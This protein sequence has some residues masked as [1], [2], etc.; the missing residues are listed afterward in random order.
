M[1]MN[2]DK[3]AQ[4]VALAHES[5]L[6]EVLRYRALATPDKLAYIFLEDGES[7][8]LPI[9]YSELDRQARRVAARLQTGS[10]DEACGRVLLIYPQGLEFVVAFFGC[11]YAGTTAVLSYPPT[12][13]KMALRVNAIATDCEVGTVLTT[14]ELF[15]KTAS[16]AGKPLADAGSAAVS[17][18]NRLASVPWICTDTLEQGSEAAFVER[19][20]AADHV[21]FLQYTSGSTG[22]PKGVMVT[23]ANLMAN[24][25]SIQAIY[26]SSDSSVGVG[27]LP[28][29][30]DMGLIGNVLHP[31]FAGFPLIFMSPLHFMQRPA[32]WLRAIAKYRAT[33]SGGPNFSYDLCSEKIALDDVAG[34]DLSCWRVAFNGAEPV[35]ESTIRRFHDKF[36][37]LGLDPQAH[38]AVYGLAEATLIVSG[39]RDNLPPV[40]DSETGT[41]SSGTA[42]PCDVVAAVDP[43]RQVEVPEG[44]EGEIWVSG[45]SVAAGYWNRAEETRETFHATLPG[46]PRR[47]LRTGDT[48]FIRNG[49]VHITGRIKDIVIVRGRNYHA[50][51]LEWSLAGIEHLR[52]GCTAVFSMEEAGRE[53]L[54]LVAGATTTDA[55]AL[56]VVV[57]AARAAVYADH[58]L[59]LDRIVLIRPKELPTTTSGKVQRRL[60]RRTLQDGGFT[61]LLDRRLDGATPVEGA[62]PARSTPYVAPGTDAERMLA[63]TWAAVLQ[64]PVEGIGLN[65]NFFELGGSSLTMLELSSR[66]DAPMELLFR[67][68]T[69]AGWLYRSAEYERPDV[70]ADIHLPPPAIDESLQGRT[71]ISMITGGTGFFGLHYLQAMMKRS[72]DRFVLPVRGV[73]QQAIERKFDEAVAYFGLQADID[74]SRVH[75]VCGDLGKPRVGLSEREYAWVARNV[76]RI[77]HIGSHVNNWLPYEGIKAIN[78]EGTRQL[79]AL[80]RTGRRKEFHY[81]STST[82]SP[83]KADKTVFDESDR[84]D[85]ADINRYFGYDLSKYV[86]EELCVLARAEGVAC[87]I[88]RL[89]WVGGHLASG[90]TKVNDGLNIMLRILLTLGCYP[91][92]EYL[93][94]VIPVDL[95]AESMASLVDRCDNTSFNVTSQSKEA[96]DMKRIVAI[97][98]GMGYR[99][100]ELSRAEFVERLRAVPAE[101]WDEQ[102]R[103]YRQLIIRLFE[104]PTPKIESYYD[105]GNF[106]SRMDPQVLA[107]MERKFIDS[108]FEKTVNFLVRRGAL[109]TP[110]GR[111]F[112]E[113]LAQ[114]EKWNETAAEFPAQA[115]LHELFER[116]VHATPD[117]PAVRFHAVTTSYRELNR[118]AEHV[119]RRLRAAGVAPR[120]KVGMSV[121]RSTA[122]IAAI[123]G[124]F[125]AGCAYVPLD[126]TYPVQ[127]LDFMIEDS[128]AASIVVDA[129]SAAQLAQHA[130]ALLVLDEAEMRAAAA[131]GA[132]DTAAAAVDAK[133]AAD[134]LAYVIY[135]SGTTGK[136][137]GVMVEHRSVVNHNHALMRAFEL[138][139]A[140]TMLQFSTVNFDSFVE[141]VFPTLFSGATLVMVDKEELVDLQRFQGA[142]R[143]QGVTIVK[144]STAFWHTIAGLPLER[145]GVRMVGIGG[146]AADL[147]KYRTWRTANPSLPLL[148]T[149]GPTEITVTA[150]IARLEGDVQ[151]ITIGRPIANTTVRVL[152]EALN[153]VP[154]GCTGELY[155]GGAGVARGYLQ[156]PELTERAF[157]DDPFGARGGSGRL[158]RSG[159]LVRWTHDGEL[160]FLGRADSQV[161]VRG[162]RIE[163][164]AIEGLLAAQ[165]GVTA[166]A[167][168]VKESDAKKKIVAY[169]SS[170]EAVLPAAGLRAA[171]E[172]ALP[173]YMLPNLIAQLPEIPVNPNG[174]V[175]RRALAEMELHLFGNHDLATP[176][177]EDEIRMVAIWE[178]LL[179][180]GGIG[181]NDAFMDLGGH[182]L[183][184]MSLVGEVNAEFGSD[185]S[186]RTVYE[187][188]TVARLLAAI[189]GGGDTAS[190]DS[191]LVRFAASRTQLA[192]QASLPPLFMVHGLG[193]HLASFHTLAENVQRVLCERYRL[194]NAVYGLEARGFRAGQACF[195]SLDEMVGAYVRQIREVQPTGPYLLGGWSFG[196]TVAF[197]VAQRLIREGDEVE[198]FISIDAEAPRVP[199]DFEDFI[200][201]RRI[202]GLDDLYEDSALGEL[203]QRFGR[204]FGFTANDTEPVREQFHRFLGY[205]AGD[206]PAQRER[207][208]R[209]AISNL[210]NARGIRP[211]RIAPR[212]TVLVRASL[213]A[214][215]NYVGDWSDLLASKVVSSITLNGDHW[216]IMQDPELAQHVA[217][218]LAGTAATTGAG[219]PAVLAAAA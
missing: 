201:S 83:L 75:L 133:A 74:R 11:L 207:Y 1:E 214:F 134:D 66:L 156:R 208:C 176:V 154:I 106:R 21:A 6:V 92:G 121:N 31:L 99:I 160:E 183:L 95:M 202:G 103:S 197:A 101:R 79:L 97:L 55:G 72:S 12:S 20:I 56:A 32:R 198:T 26:G 175:D 137:K 187:H 125:K 104:D 7:R 13:R 67:Y 147:H 192:P 24:Q 179:D 186:V 107:R 98:R 204:R 173:S 10:A 78:V 39:T 185:I 158:Y 174:K 139:P 43:E 217:R 90:K 86:S 69:I 57:A 115:C 155:I 36:A 23:H 5:T 112:D 19:T 210:Y 42:Q 161:K 37:A 29:I 168:I 178:R 65:D 136:P 188:P 135:T 70:A 59:Q 45:P 184:A 199:R 195:D 144:C 213:S 205:A 124:I 109:P 140:D 73:S 91:Q 34:L 64:I 96:I 171:L 165:P 153:P 150:T 4:T 189:R 118:Q 149:Y 30:H 38:K 84:I 58:Q 119:A 159:D 81:T 9:S 152:D 211:E 68:P 138:T 200:R 128:K 15:D 52:A 190:A 2:T 117:A 102:C 82:F 63:D 77:F 88:Y 108:W 80:A 203:L 41:M 219:H 116:Q 40:A 182:S 44:A 126:P 18:G 87:N 3:G 177:S 49:A 60:T 166:A 216:S 209:V 196:V 61:P 143:A 145:L 167:V 71:G 50:E 54:V 122:L 163:L 14:R 8:E 191:N 148:N 35:R 51:D 194:G 164:G 127:Q 17:A 146:E 89:V 33:H 113:H 212:H 130:D 111:S 28:L 76:D 157:I 94:D 46:S 218:S 180:I 141:E 25:R 206:A 110:D 123:L 22:T 169:F 170:S 53:Q 100:D 142:I 181:L 47:Y 114:M 120:D 48:G 193:G 16:M 27:W 93:H 105:S 131:D 172:V 85:P 129:A 62:A 151:C 215:E 132:L 162:Y